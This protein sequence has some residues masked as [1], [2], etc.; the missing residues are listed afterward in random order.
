MLADGTRVLTQADFLEALGKHR[1]ANVKNVKG[2]NDEERVPEIIKGVKLKPYISKELLEKSRPIRFKTPQGVKASGFRAEIL[3]EVC[4][5]YLR[6][7]AFDALQEQ[8]KPA[9]VLNRRP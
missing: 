7:R 2:Q 3:P 1:K 9:T 8:Q 6:A 4:E 5:V